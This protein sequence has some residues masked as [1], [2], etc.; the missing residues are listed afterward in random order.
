MAEEIA[1]KMDLKINNKYK[2]GYLMNEKKGTYLKVQVD[3]KTEL[4]FKKILESKGLTI[5]E[6]LENSIKDFIFQNLDCIM[7][8]NGK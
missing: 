6:V 3:N 4:A 7:I 2:G 5:Q 1:E 8:N